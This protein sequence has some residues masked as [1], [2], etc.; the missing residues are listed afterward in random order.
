MAVSRNVKVG[1]V[2]MATSADKQ[3][4][5]EK[6]AKQVA[7]AASR[8]ARIVC[9]QELFASPYFCQIEDAALF[10]LAE[11]IPGPTTEAI[12]LAARA[13]NA[14]VVTPVFERRAAGVYHN[15]VVV[16]GPQGE[17]LGLY[18]KMHIPDDPLLLRKVLLYAGRSRLR[19]DTDA[20]RRRLVR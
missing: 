16:L 20:V 8:G 7:L 1:L 17:Q 15:S 9:L 5:L 11:P 12:S 18:R 13:A 4:N 3:S 19:R 6:A 14:V 2:Q 10:D